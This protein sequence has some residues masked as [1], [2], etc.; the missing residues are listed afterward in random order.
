ML[1]AS[2]YLLRSIILVNVIVNFYPVEFVHAQRQI[3]SINHID[4][5]RHTHLGISLCYI[6]Y[7]YVKGKEESRIN[8]CLS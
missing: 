3:K 6:A 1:R 2:K 4:I 5:S 8:L 7:A